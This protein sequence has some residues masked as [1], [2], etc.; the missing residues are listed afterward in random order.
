MVSTECET[1][2]SGDRSLGCSLP[3]MPPRWSNVDLTALEHLSDLQ[4]HVLT[5]RQLASI[6]VGKRVVSHR[7]GSGEWQPYGTKV[8]AT[9]G[10]PL[11][12]EQS[13]RAA[14]LHVGPR[15]CLAGLTALEWWGLDGWARTEVHL[16]VPAGTHAT[17]LPGVSIHRSVRLSG[18]ER[19]EIDG[20][21]VTTAARAVLDGARWQRSP[22]A[23]AG[24]V[25]AAV[26]QALTSAEEIDECLHRF[27]KVGQKTALRAAL[28][29][30]ADGADSLSESI[31]SDLLEAAGFPTPIRQWEIET[32]AGRRF[33]DLAVPLGRG[34]ML[35]VEVDG[36]HHDD[37]AVRLIDAIKD[38]A[39][40][41]AGHVVVRVRA[42]DVRHRRAEV[43][44]RFRRLYAELNPA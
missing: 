25:F 38:A 42:E 15:A 16:L 12:R 24:L 5:R 27:L 20:V 3:D 6:G 40:L 18:A 34:R 44:S 29:E 19:S 41:A 21:P 33:V 28:G 32:S 9:T 1:R 2:S 10:A 35:A 31:A 22:S 36:P 39:L 23:A 30:A 11:T 17:P 8:I 26:A 14:V 7:I 4:N 37:E 13:C 43:M